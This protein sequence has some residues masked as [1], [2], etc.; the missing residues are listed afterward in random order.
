MERD[1]ILMK[2][3]WTV[4]YI[5]VTCCCMTACSTDGVN[6]Y[7]AG[8]S[9]PRMKAPLN[10]QQTILV[11]STLNNVDIQVISEN[12]FNYHKLGD[13]QLLSSSINTELSNLIAEQLIKSDF[14]SV[15][16]AAINGSNALNKQDIQAS[17]TTL[18]PSAKRFLKWHMGGNRADILI[19]ITQNGGHTLNFDLKCELG[20]AGSYN[21]AIIEPHL[22]LYKIYVIDTHHFSILTW[23]TGSANSNLQ[24]TFLCKSPK[25]YSKENFQELH[26]I[27]V[28]G[29]SQAV[30]SDILRVL[31]I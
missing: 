1:T 12:I 17:A 21:Q 5:I 22:Y 30:V 24:N 16:P 27:V 2:N 10:H 31:S 7:A 25:E 11:L 13:T 15:R 3:L 29:L 9:G 6:N 28:N 14:E 18:T 19:L 8:I 20:Q 4:F 23:V 26:E